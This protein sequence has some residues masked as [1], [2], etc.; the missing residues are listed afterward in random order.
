MDASLAL[1]D[2]VWGIERETHRIG[3]DGSVS[4]APHPVCLE[5]P[6]F[7]KDFAE[8]QLEIVTGTHG[9]SEGAILEL[10]RLTEEAWRGVGDELLWPFSMPPRLP[11]DGKIVTARMAKDGAGRAAER[12]RTGLSRRYGAS[13]QMICGVHVNVS[14]GPRLLSHLRDSAPL[15]AEESKESRDTDGFYL[16]LTRNLFEDMPLLVMA[17]GASPYG[18]R[19]RSDPP[20]GSTGMRPAFSIRNSPLGYARTEYRP[21]LELDSVSAHLAGIRRGMRTE[22]ESFRRMG[23]VLDGKPVQLNTRFFQ[24][25][26]EFYAPIRFKRTALAGESALAAIDLRGIQYLEL[27]FFD[28]DPF[29]PSGLS[30]DALRVMHCFVLDGLSRV[31]RPKTN[32]ELS[33]ILARADSSALA[34]PLV[35]T[36]AEIIPETGGRLAS[37]APIARSL[38]AEWEASLDSLS[39]ALNVPHESASARIASSFLDSGLSWTEFGTHLASGVAEEAYHERAC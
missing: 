17:F 10:E 24:K 18:E 30:R 32:A 35:K 9:S 1:Q 33:A 26:K 27:R 3:S 7:T 2:L 38:G 22:S 16:R 36:P 37:L 20:V 4:P 13:R 15:S 5:E 39:R 6:R 25:E 28:V 21:F 8:S 23:L 34:D 12:Y 31:S 29:S 19:G 11:A 14:F